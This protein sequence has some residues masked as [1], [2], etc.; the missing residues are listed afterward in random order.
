MGSNYHSS[1]T[2]ASVFHSDDMN[3]P[4]S[5]LDA[6][7]TILKGSLMRGGG[8]I[9]WDSTAGTLSWSEAIDFITHDPDSGKMAVNT[10]ASGS[11]TIPSSNM[12]YLD[13]SSVSGA[14]VSATYVAF[15]T[16]STSLIPTNRIIL[17]AVDTSLGFTPKNFSVNLSNILNQASTHTY[18]HQLN[19]SSVHTSTAGA[20]A[21]L[22]ADANGLP[23]DSSR[24]LA[25]YSGARESSLTCAATFTI[26]FSTAETRFVSLTT[27]AS[28][29][30]TG[31]E[32]GHAYKLRVQ[33]DATGNWTLALGATANSIRWEGGAAPTIT[34]AATVSDWL[35]FR[36]SN[37]TWF[38][39]ANQNF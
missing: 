38:A 11:I 12:A 28:A 23:I 19:S 37:G 27:N 17:G 1:F 20:S 9:G 5:S 30:I 18:A 16:A 39:S 4:L 21:I 33:Q 13:L 26:D 10:M 24:Q 34:T 29:I 6:A 35:T 22:I 7:I 25:E 32:N 3:P 14:T 15:S 2:T 8:T 36:R 31:G